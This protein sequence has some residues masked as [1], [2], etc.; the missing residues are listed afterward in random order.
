MELQ[1]CETETNGAWDLVS[2]IVIGENIC[3]SYIIVQ[4]EFR[5]AKIEY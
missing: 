1:L 5:L 3:Y 2:K 4:K